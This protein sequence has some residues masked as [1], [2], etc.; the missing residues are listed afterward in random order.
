M[1][2]KEGTVA[3]LLADKNHM[4]GIVLT[5]NLQTFIQIIDIC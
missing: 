4:Q 2:W 3:R 5:F 1:E